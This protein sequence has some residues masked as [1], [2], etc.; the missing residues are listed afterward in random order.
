MEKK[1]RVVLVGA[2]P[3]GIKVIRFLLE[4]PNLALVGIVDLNPDLVGKRLNELVEGASSDFSVTASIQE[5]IA[6]SGG[7]VDAAI[8]TTVSSAERILPTIKEVANQKL[9][10][11][12]TCEE[13][14][15]PWVRHPEAAR[16]IDEICRKN[17]IACLATGVNPG[18]LMDYLPAVLSSIHQ[19]V[20][21]V[22]VERV[23]DASIR[24]IPFQKKIGAGLT[25]DGFAAAQADG[26]LRHVGL[27]ESLDL[28]VASLGWQLDEN[29]ET[30]EPVLATKD[31]NQGYTLIQKGNPAGVQQIAVGI[32]DGKEVIR[33]VFR[34]AVGEE[35]S[36]DRIRI[37]GEPGAELEIKGGVNGDIAT[38]AITVNAIHSV[39]RAKPG[40]RTMLDTPVPSCFQGRSVSE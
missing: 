20:E 2:G 15:Y 29:S 7:S 22:L 30:L 27:P 24:R 14:S 11:V 5:A 28:I 39:I 17:G 34:A 10:I 37:K 32:K 8:I 19:R 38:S 13:L 6:Q 25:P 12:T 18:F 16:Q 1:T 4:R 35:S 36:Y 26:T 3:L 31:L 23:Q 33:L 9:P 21:H 40:L